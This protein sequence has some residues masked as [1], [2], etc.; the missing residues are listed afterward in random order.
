MKEFDGKSGSLA[1]K[2]FAIVVSSYHR[3]ITHKLLDGAVD[4]LREAGVADDFINVLHVPGSWELAVAATQAIRQLKPSAVICLGCVIRGETTHDQHIN[5]SV[6]NQLNQLS[7][8]S[9]TPLGFG[10]LT[11]N[12]L[13]QAV[14]RSGGEY[15]NKGRE[16]AEA[17]IEM[18]LLFDNL[19]SQQK[20]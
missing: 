19:P 17:V 8:E 9:Q 2:Q 12:T 5:T 15:G 1:G 14:A 18:L 20:S 11:C 13:E 3:N 6:S 16:C 7:C 10:L 4:K